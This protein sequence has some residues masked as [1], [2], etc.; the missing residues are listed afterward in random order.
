MCEVVRR[1]EREPSTLR[2]LVKKSSST[3]SLN[4]KSLF[5][6]IS[7]CATVPNMATV[8]VRELRQNASEIL[9][10]VEAGEP[11][12]VTVAGRPVAQIV[13]IRAERWTTWERVGAVFDSPT[14]PGWDDERRFAAAGLHDPWM[15]CM[16]SVLDTSTCSLR[17]RRRC[18]AGSP[19]AS[20]R[21]LSCSSESWLP[22]TTIVALNAW[23]A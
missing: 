11:T 7:T 9:R 4:L 2:P 10:T 1:L 22:Q 19:S 8:G 21:L 20:F 13:P 6:R 14:D 18:R 15:R 16:L 12:V 5:K 23:P 17:A 3:S